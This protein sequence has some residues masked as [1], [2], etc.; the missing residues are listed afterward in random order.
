MRLKTILF[1]MDGTL[2]DT[3]EL[4]MQSFTH[5]FQEFGLTYTRDEMTTFNGPPLID[6][7]QTI[8]PDK[9][10]AMVET[11]RR[12]N[13]A[14]HDMHVKA[15]PHVREVV[16]KLQ[17]QEMAMAVVSSKMQESIQLGLE[18]A[19]LLDLF[20]TI[21]GVDDTTHAKP[22]PESLFK[23]MQFLDAEKDTTLM[24]G[25]NYHDIEAGKNAGVLTAGVAWSMKGK[26]FL[27]QYHPTFMLDDMRDL[28][29]LV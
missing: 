17:E 6:T 18:H 1:D 8:L 3:N 28:L 21:I 5:T 12:H 7:F 24:I 13:Q 2:I 14:F 25:D 26:P 10:E 19:G 15:F 16:L 23:A 27:E 11:F 22:H 29:A 4:I 20:T 9:A